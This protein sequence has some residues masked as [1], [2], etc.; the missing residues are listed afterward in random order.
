M[1]RTIYLIGPSN[2]GK[3]TAA[4]NLA[5]S[6][7]I[8]HVNLDC[9]LNRGRGDQNLDISVAQDWAIVGPLLEKFESLTTSP[10]TL[11][12]IGAG[13][14]DRDRHHRDHKLENW[15]IERSDRVI[16]IE[17]D[18]G[19]VF[20]RYS[21]TKQNFDL[22]ECGEARRRIYGTAYKVISFAGVDVRGS[23]NRLEEAVRAL[24]M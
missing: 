10:P 7:L 22:L 21:G 11:V 13:T 8:S 3:S 18:S 1:A 2:V 4:A 16:L 9:E 19:T 15:L 6:G 5:S 14:Q 24:A 17:G 23:P 12:D 20:N